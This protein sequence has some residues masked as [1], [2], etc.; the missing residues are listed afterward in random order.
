MT[1]PYLLVQIDGRVEKRP[2]DIEEVND[3][4][5]TCIVHLGPNIVFDRGVH[6]SGAHFNG[7]FY[8]FDVDVHAGA[9][10]RPHLREFPAKYNAGYEITGAKAG[11]NYEAV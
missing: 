2:F 8:D 5:P 11:P 6:I 1:Q 9:K 4:D 3:A 10:F 7:V